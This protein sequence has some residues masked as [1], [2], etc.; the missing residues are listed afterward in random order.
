MYAPSLTFDV[1]KPNFFRWHQNEWNIFDD[2]DAARFCDLTEALEASVQPTHAINRLRSSRILTISVCVRA[3]F[4]HAQYR[5]L[6]LKLINR[7]NVFRYVCVWARARITI[8]SFDI[9]R[10]IVL[11]VVTNERRNELFVHMRFGWSTIGEY[12]FLTYEKA[13]G[14]KASHN[15]IDRNWS[16]WE[17]KCIVYSILYYTIYDY[18]RT[19]VQWFNE[20]QTQYK[21]ILWIVN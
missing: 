12:F 6:I 20:P 8:V 16:P 11:Q 3:W 1:T 14:C 19:N 17:S 4:A 5:F 13:S 18:M 15:Y 10:A 9:I 2:L 7:A 21:H